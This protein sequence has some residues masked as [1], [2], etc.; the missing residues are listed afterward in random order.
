M[1]ALLGCAMFSL[2]SKAEMDAH[3][4]CKSYHILCLPTIPAIVFSI[5][6][7]E[8]LL[9]EKWRREGILYTHRILFYTEQ[10]LNQAGS[11]VFDILITENNSFLLRTPR[12]ITTQFLMSCPLQFQFCPGTQAPQHG[13]LSSISMMA[14]LTPFKREL[15]EKDF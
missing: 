15:D 4:L 7:P 5:W 13:Q 8:I 2:H 10:P 1:Q 9:E 12:H 14:N 11:V 6:L 3:C